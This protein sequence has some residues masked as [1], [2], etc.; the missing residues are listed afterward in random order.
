[1]PETILIVI[2]Q[3]FWIFLPAGF[4][5][6]TPVFAAKCNAL[7]D[8]NYP[9]DLYFKFRGKRIFGDHKTI[10]GFL[11]GIIVGTVTSLILYQ[12][13][14]SNDSLH[15]HL[16]FFYSSTNPLVFGFLIS[17]GALLGDA[18]KSFFK[19]Q[20]GIKPGEVFFPFDQIDYIVGGLLSV[21]WYLRIPT[22]IIIGVFF[23]YFGLHLISA[24]VG[25]LLKLKDCPI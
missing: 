13:Q 15:K 24:Y 23:V 12:I 1:M 6:M 21:Y 11:S 7:K 25:Y 22:P 18:V 17:T 10:R 8:F 14:L 2:L 4:A 5:N 3:S 19:R 20:V 9:M 16:Y